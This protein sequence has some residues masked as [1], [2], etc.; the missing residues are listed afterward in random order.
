MRL[1]SLTIVGFKSFLDKTVVAFEPGIS[2]FIGP[3]GCGKSN[4]ADAI[5]WTL[6]E[7]SPKALR[8]DRM[9]DVIFNGTQSQAAIGMAEVSITLTDV[10]GQLPPPYA[11]YSEIGISRCLYRSGECDYAINGVPVRLK[12]VRDLLIDAG[13]GYRAHNVIEQG[14]VDRLI[15]ASA[16]QRREIVEEAAGITKYRLRKVEALRKLD[17][18]E[19]NLLRV[20]DI[21]SEVKRQM[22]ALDRQA[23][24]AEKYRKL[25]AEFTTL[26]VHAAARAWQTWKHVLE[27]LDRDESAGRA[28]MLG[29][30]TELSSALL[31]QTEARLALTDKETALSGM[32][33]QLFQ[34]DT[35]I[36]RLEDRIETGRAQRKEWHDLGM[37]IGKELQEIQS[38]E[39][40]L[41][42]ELSQIVQEEK[43][44]AVRLLAQES[45]LAK[46]DADTLQLERETALERSDL[47]RD[48]QA[49]FRYTSSLTQ[50]QNSQV[51]L[52]ARLSDLLRQ[53]ERGVLEGTEV[54]QKLET[55]EAE[56]AA[57][58][59]RLS[60]LAQTHAQTAAAHMAALTQAREAEA[61][62]TTL[63]PART[64]TQASLSE[65]TAQAASREG[66]YRGMLPSAPPALSTAPSPVGEIVA[67]L[68]DVPVVYEAAI[69]AVVENRLRG[70]VFSNHTEVQQ[71]MEFLRASDVGRATLFPRTPRLPQA[72]PR[73]TGEG[74]LGSALSH[75]SCR[76]GYESLAALLLDGVVIVSD[77]SVA[78]RYWADAPHVRAWVTLTGEVLDTAGT[79]SAGKQSGILEQKRELAAL[80]TA[81]KSLRDELQGFNEQVER[82]E[83]TLRAAQR[84]IETV[85][86][87]LRAIETEQMLLRKDDA[88]AQTE[89]LRLQGVLGRLV[90]EASEQDAEEAAL[91]DRI[92]NE[93]GQ[94][95]E[96]QR[97]F[98]EKET[99]L[100]EREARLDAYQRALSTLKEKG[101][102]LKLITA[103]LQERGRHLHE[104]M[105][106]IVKSQETLRR[107]FVEKG[108][109]QATLSSRA[110]ATVAEEARR[111]VE[112]GG[113]SLERER[114]LGLQRALQAE[115]TTLLEW[116]QSA[117]QA[118][119]ACRT[120]IGQAQKVLQDVAL[121]RLEA[122]MTQRKIEETTL[123]NHGVDVARLPEPEE[124]AAGDEDVARE[125]MATLRAALNDL[126][127]VHV[128]AISAYQ[129][130]SERFEFL[131]AQESDLVVSVE[132]LKAAIVKINATAVGLFVD[133]FHRMNEKFQEVFTTFFSGGS[134]ALVL[135]D[136]AHPLESG[137]EL[138]VQLPGKKSRSIGLL[139]GGEKALCA[140][141]LLFAT[142]LIHP[143]PF[144]LLDEVDAPLDEENTRRFAGALQKMSERIQFIIMTHNKR[145][146]EASDVLYGVT[147][148]E[149]G[150][151]KL[152]SVRLRG[153][154][155]QTPRDETRSG[156]RS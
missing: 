18:T 44:G 147:M 53:K 101:T 67:D 5:L 100:H 81:V 72:I 8:S 133:T 65:T 130:L 132:G 138:L 20:R 31:Q 85:S 75:V 148:E 96:Q 64:H 33:N 61:H 105:A 80:S 121:S 68:L 102:E 124:E 14:K 46:E 116:V 74:I 63:R 137:I 111:V 93:A 155:I 23:K 42:A 151:S 70:V 22:N 131:T 45:A 89:R 52:Q 57:R 10:E 86:Q 91:M 115:Q 141:S 21:V 49:L 92:K 9:E 28:Q 149:P 83:M 97:L 145:T 24:K 114:H 135:L 107:R 78:L 120:R 154:D 79:V 84:T 12:D 19:Q 73:V 3:N 123:A 13:V 122:E 150:L 119:A 34:I 108:A 126:G 11:T 60:L 125:R 26:A 82:E 98:S 25:N 17:A 16:L 59:D 71:W 134:A 54:R 146:M 128:G 109:E 152:V 62:L 106:Q 48:R 30:E 29:L 40:T 69:E 90:S 144:C 140:I 38:T 43:E 88:V 2:A 77:F 112:I 36:R 27:G 143:G 32:Q 4:L 94:I 110:D 58:S 156:E 117:D 55:Y 50:A 51:H 87:A 95:V 142:F 56:M 7:Q 35:D 47:D 76:P 6:G 104:K 41:A 127:E 39:V 129:E 136:E 153:R 66:F 139:S 103:S 113:K 15:L 37:R 99:H 118:I 1:R